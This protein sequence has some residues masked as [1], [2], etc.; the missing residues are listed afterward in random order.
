MTRRSRYP[1]ISKHRVPL[2]LFTLALAAP[3]GVMAESDLWSGDQ[4]ANIATNGFKYTVNGDIFTD[5]ATK[6][7]FPNLELNAE[8]SPANQYAWSMAWFDNKLYVGTNR[9]VH[10]TYG[11]GGGGF[12][13]E[14]DICETAQYYIGSFGL[15]GTL[16]RGEIWRY[17]PGN[18]TQ[19]QDDGLSGSWDRIFQSP[20]FSA[21][22]LYQLIIPNNK[23]T[24]D[25]GYRMMVPCNAG[26]GNT[27]LYVATFGV[28]GNIL[29]HNAGTT[30]FPASS[31]VGTYT[32]FNDI[33][34]FYNGGAFNGPPFDLG[35]RAMACF[36]KRLWVSP[37]GKL[38]TTNATASD[39][40]ASAHP[41]LMVNED[42]AKVDDS[43][44]D[45]WETVLD[46]SNNTLNP[47]ADPDNGGIFQMEA[48][49]NYLY[50][51][52]GNRVDGFELWR[53]DGTSCADDGSNPCNLVWTK[54]ITKGAGRPAAEANR[55]T[56][57]NAGATL[58][59]YGNDLIIGVGE[60]GY[61]E[62][63]FTSSELLRLNDA[64]TA[65]PKWELLA[66]WPRKAYNSTE[67]Q[68]SWAQHFIC[69]N[70]RD[71][72]DDITPQGTGN[73]F[74]FVT[75]FLDDADG[76]VANDCFPT[77][78]YGPGMG[79]V[80]DTDLDPVFKNT[81]NTLYRFGRENYFWRMAEHEGTFFIGTLG[82]PSLW[83]T[84]DGVEFTQV[85]TDG[86]NKPDTQGLRT[87]ASTP[88]GLAV[89]TTNPN[90]DYTDADG[91]PVGGGFD[92]YLGNSLGDREYL[93]PPIAIATVDTNP[94]YD[95]NGD[96]LVDH[97]DVAQSNGSVAG[98]GLVTVTL[99]DGGSFAPF[100]GV[101]GG[102][103]TYEW[104]RG[105]VANC[106]TPGS[107]PAC[108]SP[109][110]TDCTLTDVPS[111]EGSI[112]VLQHT[113]T[114]RVTSPEGI[115]CDA[116]TI[117][118]SS[119]L[120]PVPQVIPSIPF[121]SGGGR[122]GGS[123]SGRVSLI[124]F[125]NDT[126]EYYDIQGICTD[127]EG[128]QI[129]KCEWQLEEAGNT[130]QSPVNCTLPAIG[131][132]TL[133]AT[134]QALRSDLAAALTNGSSSPNISLYVEDANG[135][136]SRFRFDSSV[137]SAATNSDTAT[138][139]APVC[140]NV[141]LQTESGVTLVIDP[142]A[143]LPD[144]YPICLERDTEDAIASYNTRSPNPTKGTRAVLAGPPPALSYVSNAGIT[145][146]DK[147]G[148]RA[149]DGTANSNDAAIEVT[150][151]PLTPSLCQPGPLTINATTFA[152]T[153]ARSSETSITTSGK[154]VVAA[155]ASL[156]LTTPI[157]S[158][159][160]GFTVQAG[161]NFAAVASAV[162]CPG[163]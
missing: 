56:V 141:S 100:G 21:P 118:A 154:V 129:V 134:V 89:G 73:R 102:I 59:V 22:S 85:F 151:N 125:N 24:R 117:T 61:A 93:I 105:E 138:N 5:P 98:D 16:Y 51:S 2:L 67:A 84:D 119:D 109:T 155:G 69:N 6:T 113:F 13:D 65:N 108:T 54:L 104:F 136:N 7:G 163:T 4:F 11:G 41:I 50:L 70:E 156:S 112:D 57:E 86:L 142:T 15:P 96:G 127:L 122:G 91:N 18:G 10:C 32:T 33:I 88:Y 99:R 44:S 132:C 121:G 131:V 115:D 74:T 48:I 37:A 3:V 19:G 83:R 45:D 28:G 63:G 40:D 149:N 81:S 72:P 52:V 92:I 47:L 137:Q 95:N 106:A 12:G 133:T 161:G 26:D 17:T 116:V 77:S 159:A 82:P 55:T 20:Y 76:G 30:N 35:Y 34:D 153:V 25:M 71:I 139:V 29:Y 124:D 114:L 39:P 162:T 143:N 111:R 145:G 64:D 140:R 79:T 120:P 36:K 31:T 158:L 94:N 146:V 80:S 150:I 68:A 144:G 126:F 157:L 42:P 152:G 53:G 123:S 8:G 60:S 130:L 49:G 78:N 128:Q 90:Y 75:N 9:L 62:E 103:T 23:V 87:L 160:T 110:P 66:G 14:D 101:D 46:V 107:T 135:Y 38:E 43:L 148:F 58:G 1:A 147:F 97:F 27:R